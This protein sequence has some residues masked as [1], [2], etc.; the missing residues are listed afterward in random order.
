MI[1]KVCQVAFY[2]DVVAP[3]E[4]GYVLVET[5]R[6]NTATRYVSI[7]VHLTGHH[8]PNS[9]FVEIVEFVEVNIVDQ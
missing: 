4:N 5:T 8:L 9:G 7:A 1:T 3:H 2:A 6:G